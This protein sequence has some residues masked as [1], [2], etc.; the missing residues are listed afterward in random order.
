MAEVAAINAGQTIGALAQH[1]MKNVP[2]FR[3][4]LEAEPLRLMLVCMGSEAQ[5]SGHLRIEPGQGVRIL[6]AAERSN[7]V[8]RAHR[9]HGRPAIAL[10]I[11][12]K[13]Q[14]ALKR[15][16]KEGV[17]GM[18]EVMFELD[19]LCGMHL[20]RMPQS[21]EVAQLSRH[22]ADFADL[23]IGGCYGGQRKNSCTR[24]GPAYPALQRP[25]GHSHIIEIVPGYAP[26]SQ[27]ELNCS[28]R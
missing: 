27:T 26:A 4:A 18:A 21:S 10:F 15:R 13:N 22:T 28:I 19:N 14:G 6:Q 17:G 1:V 25:T 16:Q 24:Q 20:A 7:A 5:K 2:V 12:G 11:H 9:E 23:A 3:L 8:Y